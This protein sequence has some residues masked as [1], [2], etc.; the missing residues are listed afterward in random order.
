[1]PPDDWMPIDN[2]LPFWPR[3]SACSYFVL[4]YIPSDGEQPQYVSTSMLLGS[5][6]IPNS[7]QLIDDRSRA[8]TTK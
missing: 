6:P 4:P 5:D 2:V 8:F 3:R 1:M 7:E